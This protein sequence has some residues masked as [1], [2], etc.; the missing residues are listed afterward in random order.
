VYGVGHPSMF[1]FR[2]KINPSRLII[3]D[4]MLAHQFATL[5]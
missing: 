1:E 5:F 2:L 4:S 3:A